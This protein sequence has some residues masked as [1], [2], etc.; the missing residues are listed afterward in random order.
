MIAV[1][2]TNDYK[3]LNYLVDLSL[4]KVALC[5]QGANSRAT[6][7]LTKRKETTDMP[8]TYAEVLTSL[9]PEA[10]D[11]ITKHIE[12]QVADATAPLTEAVATLTANLAKATIA[13]A[14]V[15]PEV[16]TPDLASMLKSVAPE[17]LGYIDGINKQIKSLTD[18]QQASDVDTKFN[19][20]KS[21]PLPEATLKSI[22]AS[23]TPEVFDVMKTAA[24]AIVTNTLKSAE[25]AAGEGA[26]VTTSNEAYAALEKAAS[27]IAL[28]K[29]ITKEAAFGVACDENGALYA[30]YAKGVN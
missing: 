21:I 22:I 24:A 7:L 2:N 27:K 3:P 15:T 20:V 28:E 29:N 17:I 12:S 19:L 10:A 26:V 30:Q 8:K 23:A 1:P 18:A 9:Q 14:V 13:P 5:N 25:G 16:A 6:I 11:A 4:D